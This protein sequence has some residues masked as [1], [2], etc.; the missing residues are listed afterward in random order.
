MTL[1]DTRHDFEEDAA[2]GSGLYEIEL[3]I[4]APVSKVWEQFLDIGSWVT[5]HKIEE[6]GELR[7]EV[8]AVTRVSPS[9][10]A[11][12]ELGSE[13]AA[14]PLPHHHYCRIIDLVP[15]QQYVLKTYAEQ[16]G[17][18]GLEE[19]LAFDVSRFYA[20][21]GGTRA[22]FTLFA[23]MKGEFVTSDPGAMDLCMRTSRAGMVGN[24]ENLKRIVESA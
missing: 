17:S 11:V 6:V 16:G 14:I 10:K 13:G 1:H 8:G 4:N 15:E 23:H 21:D 20:I 7:R 2:V 22:T 5:S 24:L 9:Q 18:Y 19:F 3:V 12:D